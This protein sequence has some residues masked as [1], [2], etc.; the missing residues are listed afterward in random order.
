MTVRQIGFSI[1]RK[2]NVVE[3]AKMQLSKGIHGALKQ[4]PSYIYPYSRTANCRK[5]LVRPHSKALC[6]DSSELNERFKPFCLSVIRI[7]FPGILIINSEITISEAAE[8]NLNQLT[9]VRYTNSSR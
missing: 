1:R 7:T 4:C 5:H 9:I 2:G 8:L 6:I 3:H